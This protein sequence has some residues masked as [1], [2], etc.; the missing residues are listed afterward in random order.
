VVLPLDHHFAQSSQCYLCPGN[1]RAAGDTNPQY[2]STFVFVNDYAAVKEEQTHYEVP[3]QDGGSLRII[4]PGLS[5][6]NVQYRPR[7][8]TPARRA[9][10]WQMLR[11]DL[12]Q[13]SQSHPGRFVTERNC[14][15]HPCLDEHLRVASVPKVIPGQIS[16]S[17]NTSTVH[18]HR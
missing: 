9:C 2:E 15:N 18:S 17:D 11:L 4:W 6:L 12:L 3:D 7:Q 10:H 16:R 14:P 5:F 8:P 1:K 13:I